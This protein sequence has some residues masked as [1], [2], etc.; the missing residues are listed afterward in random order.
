MSQPSWNG[1][2]AITLM[3][4]VTFAALTLSSAPA[5]AGCRAWYGPWDYVGDFQS[6]DVSDDFTDM[7]PPEDACGLRIV[8]PSY[9]RWTD[10]VDGSTPQAAKDEAARPS[11][12]SPR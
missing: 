3:G 5:F 9:Y 4:V 10:D 11:R 1:R 8:T 7:F 2:P 6:G 12:A